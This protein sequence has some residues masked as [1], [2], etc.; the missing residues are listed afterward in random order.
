MAPSNTTTHDR[1][2][3]AVANLHALN[4]AGVE[5]HA[6]TYMSLGSIMG[7]DDPATN[8]VRAVILDRVI[9]ELGVEPGDLDPNRYMRA[10]RIAAR[11]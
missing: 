9:I 5:A 2:T 3:A 4:R 11:G 6:Q 1:I 10:V 7:Y 8:E